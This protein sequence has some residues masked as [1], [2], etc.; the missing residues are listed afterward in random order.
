MLYISD[1]EKRFG[2]RLVLSAV[3]LRV[4]AGEYVAVVGES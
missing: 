4:E 2:D 1:V 3:S